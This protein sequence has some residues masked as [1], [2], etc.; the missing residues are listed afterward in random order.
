MGEIKYEDFEQLA[1][2]IKKNLEEEFSIKKLSGNLIRTIEIINSKDKIEIS[3]PA[4]TYN[5]LQYQTNHVVIPTYRG[6]YASKLDAIGSEFFIYPYGTRKGSFKIKPH[7]HKDFV[8]KVINKSLDEWLATYSN[9]YKKK[10]RK[11]FGGEEK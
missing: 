5:M 11:D 4:P 10:S 2:I 8:D 7:N 3:I 9:K 1:L 6:S